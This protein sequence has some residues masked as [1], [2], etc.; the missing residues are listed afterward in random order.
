[1]AKKETTP[2]Q[3]FFD[4][5][6]M[7]DTE[8]DLDAVNEVFAN[9]TVIENRLAKDI[10]AVIEEIGDDYGLLVK[11]EIFLGLVPEEPGPEV[12][13]ATQH[14]QFSFLKNLEHE[15]IIK[16]L[17]EIRKDKF[18]DGGQ[19]VEVFAIMSFYPNEL[20][21][22]LTNEFPR[23]KQNK[24]TTDLLDGFLYGNPKQKALSK[25]ILETNLGINNDLH[26]RVE[27]LESKNSKNKISSRLK[28]LPTDLTWKDVTI[29]FIDEVTVEITTKNFGHRYTYEELGFSK[30]NTKDKKAG[31]QWLLLA[32]MANILSH[33]NPSIDEMARVLEF[34]GERGRMALL[35]TKRYLSIKLSGLFEIWN[36]PIIFSKKDQHYILQFTLKPLPI[37]R[38]DKDPRRVGITYNDDIEYNEND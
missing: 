15:G 10:L 6:R 22:Y 20:K 38:S 30:A 27:L 3:E 5:V 32:A 9:K 4:Q 12:Q 23:R 35:Q 21:K 1:M 13:Q 25:K 17:K 37:L 16:N 26:E 28:D 2:A 29:T 8:A 7:Y 31:K 34:H 18:D 19:R 33:G 11:K 36:D 14:V 24:T